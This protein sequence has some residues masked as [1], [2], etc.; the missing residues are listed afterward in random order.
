VTTC[1]VV[2]WPGQARLVELLDN[3]DGTLSTV[4]TMIDHDSPA[5]PPSAGDPAAREPAA[6][7]ALHRELAAN[8]PWAGLGS[9]LAGTP[10]DRN[11]ELVLRAPF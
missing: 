5:R 9:A 11:V 10:A 8:V 6:L 1:A 7:A 2:D 3:G 4:C